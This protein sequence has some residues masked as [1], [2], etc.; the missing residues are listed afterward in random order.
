MRRRILPRRGRL[1]QA[2]ADV[3]VRVRV[4][5]RARVRVES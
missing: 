2:W 4:R 1:V 3:R 5:V